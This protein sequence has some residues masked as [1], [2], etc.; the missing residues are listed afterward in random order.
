MKSIINMK[1]YDTATAEEIA[2]WWNGLGRTDFR[3]CSET[4]YQ[5]KSGAWFLHGDGGCLSKYAESGE[6]NSTESGETIIPYSSQE[7]AVWLAGH[8]PS[9]FRKTFP[10]P[11][12]RCLTTQCHYRPPWNKPLVG[13]S[14]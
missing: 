8:N 9:L 14:P 3:F 12:A 11:R 4:L 6:G 1:R 7:A 10:E 13:N 5:T 2:E